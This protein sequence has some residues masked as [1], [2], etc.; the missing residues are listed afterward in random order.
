MSSV[1][2]RTLVIGGFDRIGFDLR[3]YS[4]IIGTC[5]PAPNTFGTKVVVGILCLP[6]RAGVGKRVVPVLNFIPK[7]SLRRIVL[8]RSRS[9]S[10][11]C[12]F[13]LSTGT[14]YKKQH[15]DKRVQQ[16]HNWNWASGLKKEG[17]SLTN[18][19]DTIQIIMQ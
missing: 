8:H 16:A 14:A 12:V 17:E 7:G 6:M 15:E 9:A 4:K 11:K 18:L 1:V 3:I 19:R 10:K 5:L 2:A 13:L